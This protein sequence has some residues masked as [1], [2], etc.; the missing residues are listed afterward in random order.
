MDV[1][2]DPISPFRNTL[3]PVSTRRLATHA[4]P[5]T[6]VL[7]GRTGP[8]KLA[9]EGMSIEGDLLLVRPGVAHHVCLSDQGADVLY[10]NGVDFPFD[11]PL[12]M[13][14]SGPLAHCAE[15]AIRGVP[16]AA[17]DLRARLSARRDKPCSR[18]A[19]AVKSIYAEPMR[20]MSQH[21]LALRLGLERTQALRQFKEHTGQTFRAFKSWSG[22][23]YAATL[24]AGGELVRTSAMDAGFADTAHL[25]RVF[26]AHFGLTP[27]A[28]LA[29]LNSA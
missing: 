22:L 8:L 1:M 6:C 20:R 11:A 18:L 19:E 9:R 23:Q 26:S 4:N 29:A 5:V 12:A 7:A 13:R 3:L 25:S 14:L 16:T 21:E 27:S 28:A 15:A 17:D 24:M 2:P 10:L